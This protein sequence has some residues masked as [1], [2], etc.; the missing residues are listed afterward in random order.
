MP[1]EKAIAV[2]VA[3]VI[4]PFAMLGLSAWVG[5]R[6]RSSRHRWGGFIV[7]CV[8]GCVLAL[9]FWSSHRISKYESV[10]FIA[11]CV[12]VFGTGATGAFAGS[13]WTRYA[14]RRDL[15]GGR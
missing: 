10:D 6:N 9:V 2:I 15:M 5:K 11:A 7:G 13:L 4:Y 12:F 3:F 14:E 8:V 1:T